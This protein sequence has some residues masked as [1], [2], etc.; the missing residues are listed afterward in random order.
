MLGY[1]N[2]PEKTT[3]RFVQNPLQSAYPELIYRTDDLVT[4]NEQ[5]DPMYLSRSD[6]QSKHPGYRIEL[7]ETAAGAVD[8]GLHL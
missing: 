3:E 6:F 2:N 5:G 4:Y 7:G 1:Y 8:G